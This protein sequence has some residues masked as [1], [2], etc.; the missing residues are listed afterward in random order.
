[1]PD[2]WEADELQLDRSVV[3]FADPDGRIVVCWTTGDNQERIDLALNIGLSVRRFVPHLEAN[4]VF[5][6]MDDASCPS[7]I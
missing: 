4:F 5:I 2:S 1:M 6:A 7:L 3:E